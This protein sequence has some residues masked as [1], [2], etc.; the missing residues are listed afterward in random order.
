[1]DYIVAFIAHVSYTARNEAQAQKRADLIGEWVETNLVLP[2]K[3][4]RPWLGVL[5][6]EQ[7]D[8]EAV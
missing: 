4:K 5:E 7:Q 8:F 3:R 6:S 1:M 2:D